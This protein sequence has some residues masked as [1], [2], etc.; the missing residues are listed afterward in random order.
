MWRRTGLTTLTLLLAGGATTA[1]REDAARRVRV[2]WEAYRTD[3][4]LVDPRDLVTPVNE[5]SVVQTGTVTAA[6]VVLRGAPARQLAEDRLFVEGRDSEG[7]VRFETVIPD[8]RVLRAEQSDPEGWVTGRLLHRARAEFD[9][10]VPADPAIAEL[11]FYQPRCTG[12]GWQAVP[13]GNPLRLV[14]LGPPSPFTP[15]VKTSWRVTPVADNGAP[16]QRIDLV[17][18]GDGYTADELNKYECDVEALLR[19]LFAQAPLSEYRRYFNVHRV[20]VVSPES[21]AD[22]P[23]LGKRVDTALGASFDC[24]CIQRLICVDQAAVNAAVGNSLPQTLADLV[25][26]LVNDPQYGGSGGAIAVASTHPKVVELV[27]HEG[28]HSFGLLADEY[29]GPPPPDCIDDVEPCEPNATLNPGRADAKW[30]H[31]LDRS[32]TPRA[33]CDQPGVPAICQGARYCDSTLYRPTQ[34]SKMRKLGSAFDS[35]NSEQLVRR[36]Y[37]HVS[38]IDSVSPAPGSLTLAPGAQQMFSVKTPQPSTQALK[39]VWKLDGVERSTTTQF[40]FVAPSAPG[41]H[42]V[43]VSVKDPTKLVRKDPEGLLTASRSWTV[44]VRTTP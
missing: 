17:I 32:P 5:L 28:G 36:I 25:L 20:N 38:P 16:E 6:P 24:D 9:V 34:Q 19:A 3:A 18:L 33:A 22:H 2:R 26:V 37:S 10:V 11:R 41:D 1:I 27:L 42:T 35:I 21:G 39:I 14:P 15:A 12:E 7:K 29:G 44:A 30:N 31:W 4:Q 40:A 23:S 13:L 43:T 8:P